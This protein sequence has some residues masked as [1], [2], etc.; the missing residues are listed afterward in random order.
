MRLE[1][2][3][4]DCCSVYCNAGIDTCVL[5]DEAVWVYAINY[6]QNSY[7]YWTNNVPKS[8]KVQEIS[9]ARPLEY[10]GSPP[11][12]RNASRDRSISWVP[13][14]KIPKVAPWQRPKPSKILSRV[15]T[16]GLT[17]RLVSLT[18]GRLVSL[19]EPAKCK[20][21]MTSYFTRELLFPLKDIYFGLRPFQFINII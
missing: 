16:N 21:A 12:H 18:S 13:P 10:L 4:L 17:E 15:K 9:L 20:P 6:S 14:G 5:Q 8:A 3:M 11:L 2:T 1:C 7:L 19:N